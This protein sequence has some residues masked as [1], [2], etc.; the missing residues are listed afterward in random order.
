[1]IVEGPKQTGATGKTEKSKKTGGTS[2]ASFSEFLTETTEV[3]AAAPSVP[4]ASVNLFA[5]LQAAEH[6]TDQEQRRQA[7]TEADD[8]LSDLEDLRIGLLLGSYT[9]NQ[10]RNLASKLA[11]RR[12]SVSD[13]ALMSLLEDIQ[14]R[15][16][17]EL[18]KYE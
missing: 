17:V 13:P 1:M 4:V 14:L 8:L 15:A 9:L 11:R 16:A 18:A 7:I 12:V 2:G 3:E 10:L 5:A 6:A